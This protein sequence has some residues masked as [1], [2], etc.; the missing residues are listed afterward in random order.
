MARE[1]V[2]GRRYHGEMMEFTSTVMSRVE[3]SGGIYHDQER[4]YTGSWFDKSVCSDEH[5]IMF[6]QRF[7]GQVES[8][9]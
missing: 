5:M 6:N 8:S 7:G 2:M 3:Q 4:W 9:T 1:R